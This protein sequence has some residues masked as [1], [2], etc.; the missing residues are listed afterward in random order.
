MFIKRRDE[1]LVIAVAG[2]VFVSA[3]FPPPHL[4]DDVDAAQAQIAR[5]MLETGDW[6]T[7]RLNGVVYLEKAPL[8]YWLIALAFA[9]FGVHD[10]AARLPIGL[11]VVAL[12]WLT[13]R[14]GVWA[15]GARAGFHAGL[16]LA[17]SIGLFLFTRI[18]IADVL[19]TLSIALA[20]W[21]FL[22]AT[23]L[24][25]VRPRCWS[26]VVAIS[27]AAGFLFKGFIGLIFPLA[28]IA[29]Y[30]LV[31]G[32]WR[33]RDLWQR[34]Q[35]ATT[36][37]IVLSLIL[38][39]FVAATVRN[40]PWFDF[41]L[42]SEPGKYR[43][44]F[45]FFVFN[46]HVLRFLGR[47]YPRDY[48]TVPRLWFWLSHLVWFFPWSLFL[49][50]VARLRL[51]RR[52]A[53]RAERLTLLAV[54]W[55]GFVMV[56]FSFS[57]TQEYYSLPIYPA[58]A[59]LLGAALTKDGRFQTIACWTT[60]VTAGLAALVAA[61]LLI[62][63]WNTPT[64]GDIAQALAKSTDVYAVYTL[65]LG[66]LGD[67]TVRSFA[68]L[69]LPLTLAA[70]AFLIGAVGVHVLQRRTIWPPITAM[71]TLLL[72]AARIAMTTF[73]PYLGSYPL[74][75]A[76]VAAQRTHPGRVVVDNQYYAFSSVFFYA[77]LQGALLLNG[78]TTNLEYGSY[79]PGAPDVF[80]DDKQFVALWRTPE[81]AYLLVEDV[82]LPR[83]E[84]LVGA[85]ALYPVAAS[86]GKFLLCNQPKVQ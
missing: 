3:C 42:T 64:P 50:G 46:E 66:H 20:L 45:W 10:W 24:E 55:I 56:F 70:V 74:A 69:R 53:N 25:E 83:I 26:A 51:T 4:M 47:R 43:G 80:L 37:V 11:G 13:L 15:F 7:P 6:I 2:V 30:A 82:H 33:Q 72:V 79:A 81:R 78:R 5:T 77:N 49:P 59:L 23:D 40:P 28:A 35:P 12:C 14:M 19:L 21:A 48:N 85:T 68:Y 52:P 17:T 22:R 8:K 36:A 63:N 34:L 61:A 39:W 58:V 84:R 65:S 76:L 60:S 44:F 31:T 54:V 86:G 16:I 1:W 32:Q 73:D 67:L 41:A 62:V 38:P 29:L 57:T 27:L 18:L 71:L 75:Q 9:V